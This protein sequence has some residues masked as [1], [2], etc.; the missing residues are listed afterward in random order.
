VTNSRIIVIN[1][2]KMYVSS[3]F[4]N[5]LQQPLKTLSFTL[6]LL[7]SLI[8]LGKDSCLN[9]NNKS[10]DQYIGQYL[11]H[12]E[13]NKDEV[14]HSIDLKKVNFQ[15]SE[16]DV[17][18]LGLT[19]KKHI[20][21]LTITNSSKNT[22]FYL[23]NE[24]GSISKLQVYSYRNLS[25][26][27]EGKFGRAEL[28]P[29]TQNSPYLQIPF[30]LEPHDTITFYFVAESNLGLALA[31]RV[32]STQS[33]Q[34]AFFRNSMYDGFF[35]GALI[36]MLFYNLF[37]FLQTKDKN[38]IRYVG[39]V[40]CTFLLLFSFKGHLYYFLNTPALARDHLTFLF[41]LLASFSSLHFGYFFFKEFEKNTKAK[42]IYRFLVGAIVLSGITYTINHTVG[43]KSLYLTTT[44]LIIFLT[45][46]AINCYRKG[47]TPSLYYAAGQFI[48]F[49]TVILSIMRVFKLLPFNFFTFHIIEIGVLSDLVMF[50][51]ALAN[52]INVLNK[53]KNESQQQL[54][55]LE[56]TTTKALEQQI[57]ESTKALNASLAK[58]KLYFKEIHHRVKNNL[59]TISSLLSLQS[60]LI[61]DEKT[62]SVLLESTA[63]IKSM[64]LLHQ[65]LYS[66]EEITG[67]I[68]LKDYFKT[69]VNHTQSM[70]SHED[71]KINL[72]ITNKVQ[73]IDIDLAINLG[74][75]LNELLTNSFKYAF[76]KG[77][78]H[79]ITISINQKANFV[80][81]IYSDS[82]PGYN[83]LDSKENSFGLTIVS[84][85]S[86]QINA[87]V[88]QEINKS[89]KLI[90]QFNHENINS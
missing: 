47:H 82:G 66:L 7:Y 32:Q 11:Y 46:L 78:K 25:L 2:I 57:E 86:K 33:I 45:T 26:N 60:G 80:E 17:L 13:L 43:L 23:Q 51:V 37:L 67:D 89:S 63:R 56:R 34:N 9:L 61:Q 38:Y 76:L 27:N 73:Q 4:E 88:S 20:V 72:Q 83:Y 31:M 53:T 41:I 87:Q 71:L 3:R 29:F 8:G 35:F 6:F 69:L 1:A 55:E 15:K 44:C 16:D 12:G 59:Q 75:I 65:K 40:F 58:N 79:F 74:L 52:K 22:E 62:K 81:F 10:F 64:A 36:I 24:N 5:R 42:T 49:T 70:F 39:Y 84:L 21:K 90:F 77:D 85:I 50:S 48:M 54:L 68:D 18:N 30:K 19:N 14:F 28:N